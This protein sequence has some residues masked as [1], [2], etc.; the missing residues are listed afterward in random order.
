MIRIRT[1]AL[2]LALLTTAVPL[3]LADDAHHPGG[4]AQGTPPATAPATPQAGAPASGMMGGGMMGAD[5]MSQMMGM[6]QMMHGMGAAGAS[7]MAMPGM[8]MADRVEGRIA[9]LR[10]ELK[11]TDAQSQAW[12]GFAEALRHAAHVLQSSRAKAAAATAPSPTQRLEQQEQWYA[13]RLDGIR[14]LKAPVAQLYAALSDEQKK[15]ADQLLP[16]HLGMMPMAM[17]A[18]GAMPMHAPAAAGGKH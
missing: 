17:M 11:I 15:T 6:M 16:P 13:A 4:A 14:A 18:M 5:H 3:A 7:A 9:F 12:N 10:A 1:S 8:D 2:A